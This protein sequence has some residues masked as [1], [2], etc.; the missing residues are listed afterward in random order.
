MLLTDDLTALDDQQLAKWCAEAWG[1]PEYEILGQQEWKRRQPISLPEKK[2]EWFEKPLGILWLS[3]VA[4]LL[5]GLFF[6]TYFQTSP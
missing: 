5:V 6:Y 3:V 2:K 1:R 4:S